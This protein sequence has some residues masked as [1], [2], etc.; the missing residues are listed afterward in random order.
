MEACSVME[1]YGR[2]LCCGNMECYVFLHVILKGNN[3]ECSLLSE[4]T[5]NHCLVL[6][7]RC[8]VRKLL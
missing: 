2:M 8:S 7:Y 4:Q 5:D 6:L 3:S 1:C